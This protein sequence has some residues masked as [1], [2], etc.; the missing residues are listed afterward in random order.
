MAQGFLYLTAVLDWHSR[1]VLSWELSNTLAVDFC[2][3]ALAEALRQAP[4]RTSSTPT[5][6]AS[7]PARPT[8]RPCCRPAAALAATGGA[9]PPT[10]PSSSA[11]GAP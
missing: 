11:S 4:A 6:A 2:L 7:L 9:G 1:Y 8:S 10:T 5:R 3:S